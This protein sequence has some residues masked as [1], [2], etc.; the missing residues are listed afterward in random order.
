[1]TPK[2]FAGRL[3]L[4]DR[5]VQRW[6]AAGTFPEVRSQRKNRVPLMLL[7]PMSSNAGTRGSTRG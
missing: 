5:T 7:H 1:M 4:S 2:E 6:L 3:G